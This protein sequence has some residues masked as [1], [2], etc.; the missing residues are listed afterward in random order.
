MTLR[1]LHGM[2]EFLAAERLQRAV[3]GQDDSPDP[4]DLMMVV[5]AEGGLCA[6]AFRGGDLVAYVF[7]FPTRD[8]LVQHS[9]RLAVLPEARGL[10]LGVRLK[11]YQRDWCLK[12]G[13]R[14]VRWTFD[15]LRR[16]NATLNIDTLGACGHVYHTDYYGDMAGINAGA[17]S[18]RLSVEWRLDAP[19]VKARADGQRSRPDAGSIKAR[20]N[21]PEDFAALLSGAPEAALSERLR[22]R[23]SLQAAFA[24]G[25]EIGG[26]DREAGD[27]LLVRRG[28]QA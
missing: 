23:D 19:G 13:T 6:G 16:T 14:L 4:A 1:D 18:D 11:W 26:F 20:V 8:P 24:Q 2:A 22:V 27:Y 10:K 7:G 9:H 28:G 25:L 5:Q 3:W 21:I 17:P 12:H 15:P